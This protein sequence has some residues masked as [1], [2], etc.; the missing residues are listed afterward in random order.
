MEY[1]IWAG[2][3]FVGT[4]DA[5]ENR[6]PN[7]G[8]LYLLT[9]TLISLSFSVDPLITIGSSLLAGVV[10]FLGSLFMYMVRAMA[11]GD[12]KLLG[13]VGV[14]VGWGQLMN[15]TFWIAISS[16]MIGGLYGAIRMAED[17][18]SFQQLLQKYTMIFAY[19]KSAKASAIVIS[20]DNAQMLRMPF[21][22]VVVIGLAMHSFFNGMI[23]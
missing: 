13:V 14:I 6:I 4:T 17:P 8:L 18:A 22:P 9:I 12:V 11:P 21:A 5:R 1:L 20:K 23:V 2:L 19:G 15:A 3:L 16:V 10:M 7:L